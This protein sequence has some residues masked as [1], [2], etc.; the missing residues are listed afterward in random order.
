[1]KHIALLAISALTGIFAYQAYWLIGLYNQ[2]KAQMERNIR[3]A[4]RVSDYKEI[5]KRVKTLREDAN[6]GH[7]KIEVTSGITE[8]RNGKQ[9]GNDGALTTVTRAEFHYKDSLQA[10]EQEKLRA[11]V[12]KKKALRISYDRGKR[13][14]KLATGTQEKS[15]EGNETVNMLANWESLLE[16]GV[17]IQRGI[18]SGV[19]AITAPDMQYLDKVLTAHLDSIGVTTPHRLLYL[20]NGVGHD[21]KHF[22]DTLNVIGDEIAGDTV[23]YDYQTNLVTRT[24]YRLILPDTT[25]LVVKQMRGILATS[26]IIILILSFVF[27]YLLHTI[28]KQKTLDEMKSD[29]TNNITHELKTPIAVAYAA[30]DALLNFDVAGDREKTRQYLRIGQEQLG[31]L[32]ELVEQILSVSMERRNAMQL[33]VESLNLKPVIAALV[34]EQQLKADKP[35]TIAAD[36]EDGIALRTDKAHFSNIITNILDNAV[37]YSGAA[38][39]IKIAAMMHGNDVEI[40]IA[41][42]GIGIAPD[43]MKRIFDKFYRVPH[44]NIHEVKG[45]GLGLYYVKSMMQKLGGEVSAES[46]Q[47]VGTTF[48]LVFHG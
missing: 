46:E 29:F 30:N 34:E 12:M 17:V 2:E 14:G 4:I 21:S 27:W 15:L 25:L 11:E 18:H 7:G 22:T 36:I 26:L 48:K 47:G 8:N 19:D 9:T 37:K 35:M 23:M 16:L 33:N 41:D 6:V 42:N 3:E 32:S 24:A 5:M 43:N 45:Y 13:T 40:S 1:M 44:G 10:K 28:R 20:F 38:A 39:E 31:R